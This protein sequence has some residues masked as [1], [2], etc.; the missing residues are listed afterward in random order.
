MSVA[1]KKI[2]SSLVL[3][4][5]IHGTVDDLPRVIDKLKQA[6][7]DAEGGIPFTIIHFPLTDEKGRTMDVC[8][9]LTYAIESADFLVVT[10]VRIGTAST[11]R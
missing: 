10:L 7:G 6:A 4:H 9:P 3:T 1:Y 5:R 2:S 11:A 8:V